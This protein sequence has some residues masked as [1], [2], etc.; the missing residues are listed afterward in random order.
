MTAILTQLT[1]GWT[2]GAVGIWTLVAGVIGLWWKGLPAII[3]AFERKQ[4]GVELR[5]AGL[6]DDQAKRFNEQLGQADDRHD[7]CMEGQRQLRIEMAA[8]RVENSNLW[9]TISAMRQGALSVE[10]VVAKTIQEN[11]E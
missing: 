6:L 9:G 3:D 5:I 4:S 10:T 7:E 1:G 2:P 11:R 8:L